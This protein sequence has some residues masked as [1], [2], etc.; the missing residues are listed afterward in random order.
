MAQESDGEGIKYI[1]IGVVG[2][3][4][5]GFAYFGIIKPVLI[6]AGVIDSKAEKEGLKD[7]EKLSR[8]G[9]LNPTLY[10]DNKQLISIGS[11][12]AS[13]L[14][15]NVYNGRW[16]GCCVGFWCTCD[17]EPKGISG[18]S[19]AGSKVNISYVSYIFNQTYNKD[20]HDY[21]ESYL[22]PEDWTTVDNIINKVKKF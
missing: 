7:E 1:V 11:G 14:S 16:G 2:L 13:Q 8:E 21:L 18:I 10:L 4:V 9:V 5:V 12:R 20:M 3:T 17:D 15:S 22:E 6:A 19:G